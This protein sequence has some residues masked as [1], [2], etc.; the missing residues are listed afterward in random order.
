MSDDYDYSLRE[1]A[2]ADIVCDI[3]EAEEKIVEAW[4]SLQT[5]IEA[6]N[7]YML[8]YQELDGC[9]PVDSMD[10]SPYVEAMKIYEESKQTTS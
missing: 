8:E 5:W 10:I 6:R 3:C 1:H 9:Y 2:L 4:S 7:D